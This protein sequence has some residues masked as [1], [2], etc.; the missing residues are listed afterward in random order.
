MHEDLNV[1]WNKAPLR[2]LTDQQELQ[3][4]QFP[5]QYAAKVEWG[6][7]Q[8]RDMSVIGGMFAGQHA[9]QL[10]CQSC[11]VTS[12]TYEAFW[13]LSLEI[14]NVETCDL[15]DCLRSYC[16]AE[17]LAGDELW[18]CPRCKKDRE[19]VKKITIT[20]APDTLVVHFKR[21]SASRT[22]SARKIRTP[23]QF[24]LQ[25]LDMGPF[26]EPPMTQKERD[27]VAQNARDG[28]AQ[29]AGITSDPTMNGP[30]IY[31]AYAVIWHIGNT[32]GSGHYIA[33]V[34]DKAKGTWRSFNDDKITDFEP[35]NLAPQNRLQNEK[36][37]I[38][39]YERER[40]AGGAF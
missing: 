23:V 34:K 40:V 35:A 8:H 12:T 26:I 9:S 19:A 17:R 25:S 36:A 4:E 39:F 18:R 2:P 20:R 3:R 1:T 5:R 30:F 32:L 13:S 31:N 24:P 11:G 14:P 22:E 33:F 15:R 29:V 27:Y 6:R 10:T 21:F 37:Y 7:Y 16:A 28:P 38:V